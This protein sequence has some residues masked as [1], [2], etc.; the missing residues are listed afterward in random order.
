MLA[1]LEVK[2]GP[3]Y[4]QFDLIV[5]TSTGAILATALGLGI[6]AKEIVG[7]YFENGPEIFKRRWQHR[8]GLLGSK[9]SSDSL[10]AVLKRKF[11]DQRFSD[12]KTKTMVTSTELT[13][14]SARFWKSWVHGMSAGVAAASSAAAP[15]YFDP[16]H[17][18]DESGATGYYADG[19]LFANDP[20]LYAL[21]EAVELRGFQGMRNVKLIDI[22][23]PSQKI[24]P[25]LGKGVIGFG[26]EACEAFLEVG[27]DA[28]E[29]TCARFLGDN[30]LR[31][32]P[33]LG[34]ASPALDD[35]SAKN[36]GDLQVAGFN[37]VQAIK[38]MET[39]LGE[40]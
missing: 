34:I 11:N 26:P 7:F 33:Q 23:C 25:A 28:V 12:C 19:S 4:K 27:M 30:Y 20:A 31:V 36:L 5:G 16:I 9:Y 22:A 1:Q 37:E 10:L 3:L 18:T 14:L 8:L 29:T 21:S 6:P 32:E 24:K 15:T 2:V 39:F 38:R 17:I 40:K 35:V 13:R